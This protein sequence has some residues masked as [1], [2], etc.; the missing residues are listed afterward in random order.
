M[1][2]YKEGW[3]AQQVAHAAMNATVHTAQGD[4]TGRHAAKILL[5][6]EI[7]V[8]LKESQSPKMVKI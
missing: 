3:S 4:I 6:S 2:I 1:D 8:T 5:L 7:L